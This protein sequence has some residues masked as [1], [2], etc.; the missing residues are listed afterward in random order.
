MKRRYL[1]QV[2][3]IALSKNQNEKQRTSN[4]PFFR[5][6][7]RHKVVTVAIIEANRDMMPAERLKS[8][9]YTLAILVSFNSPYY[10]ILTFQGA[11]LPYITQ[12]RV[13][14]KAITSPDATNAPHN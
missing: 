13:T 10:A 3:L 2:D 7:A 12:L 4:N 1:H 6:R 9:N 8:P 14:Y 5:R 11:R